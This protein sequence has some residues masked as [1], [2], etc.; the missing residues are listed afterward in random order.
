VC[1]EVECWSDDVVTSLSASLTVFFY[2]NNFS[3]D[4]GGFWPSFP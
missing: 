1:I 2:F 4:P 3:S